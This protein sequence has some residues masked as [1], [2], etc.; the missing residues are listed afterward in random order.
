MA[1]E[2]IKKQKKRRK[3]FRGI[4]ISSIFIF[5]LFRSVPSILANN[6][7]TVLPEKGL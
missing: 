1:Y 4:I 7:K 5:I 6:S 3:L 2:R